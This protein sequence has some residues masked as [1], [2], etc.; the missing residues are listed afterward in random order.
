MSDSGP[1]TPQA[2]PPQVDPRVVAVPPEFSGPA[3]PPPV[4]PIEPSPPTPSSGGSSLGRILAIVLLVI[5]VIIAIALVVAIGRLAVGRAQGADPTPLAPGSPATSTPERGGDAGEEPQAAALTA[6]Q[7]RAADDARSYLA[8]YPTSRLA[9][10]ERLSGPSG[11]EAYSADDVKVAV[12]SL[13]VDWIAMAT[14]KA[15]AY[16]ADRAFSPEGLILTLSSETGDRFTLDEA[17]QAVNGLTVDWEAEALEYAQTIIDFSHAS[18]L[19]LLDIMTSDT[20]A[21]DEDVAQRAIDA[22]NA[23]WDLEAVE[24]AKDLLEYDQ[25][26]TC[27]VLLDR[28]AGEYGQRYTPEEAQYAGEAVGLC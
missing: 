7:Q 6:T 10:M 16:L 24:A 2:A 11:G 5:A 21:F 18:R 13:G 19:Q 22:T 9:L 12:D 26:S 23:N 3:G 4:S 17:T 14:A 8:Q 28:L 1:D 20:Q 15:E 27:E 25:I